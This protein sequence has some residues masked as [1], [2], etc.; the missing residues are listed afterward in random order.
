M[1]NGIADEDLRTLHF[2]MNMPWFLVNTGLM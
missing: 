2:G 1:E